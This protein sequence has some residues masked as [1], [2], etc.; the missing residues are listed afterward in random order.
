MSQDEPS[1]A[2]ARALF[3]VLT[4]FGALALAVRENRPLAELKKALGFGQRQMGFRAHMIEANGFFLALHAQAD[5]GRL[6]VW[7][8][9]AASRVTLAYPG[10]RRPVTL[11]PDGYGEWVPEGGGRFPFYLEWDRHAGNL[12][13]LREKLRLYQAHYTARLAAEEGQAVIPRLLFVACDASRMQTVWK[14]I[15]ALRRQSPDTVLPVLLTCRELVWRQGPLAT[16]WELAPGGEK[17]GPWTLE[18]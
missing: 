9:E 5:E 15:G 18:V 7:R 12:A 16:I 17:A 13:K 14:Q 11:R 8:A 4:E 10:R 6:A 2:H 3:Y 1:A